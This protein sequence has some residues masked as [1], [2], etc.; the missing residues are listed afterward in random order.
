MRHGPARPGP[1]ALDPMRIV[2]RY[3]TAHAAGLDLC[4][5][6]D[7]PIELAPRARV[8]VATGLAV[9]I[10][11]G[12][13]GQVRPRSGLARDHG[14]TLLNSPGTIDADYTG[15][16]IVLLVNHGIG[17]V[18]GSR[19]AIAS[20]S[21]CDR[22][23]SPGGADRR[24]HTPGHGAWCGRFRI[25]RAMTDKPPAPADPELDLATVNE[26]PKPPTQ[27]T[28]GTS[29]RP[30]A[31]PKGVA[32]PSTPFDEV[33]TN[34]VEGRERDRQRAASPIHVFSMKTPGVVGRAASPVVAPQVQLRSLAGLRPPAGES[35]QARPARE[36]ERSAPGVR[37]TTQ[38][39]PRSSSCSRRRSRSPCGS[40]RGNRLW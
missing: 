3:M 4:A 37:A 22:A 31:P 26:R 38:P 10:P 1:E 33:K 23:G 16:L 34:V 27:P 19:T 36:S 12:Y 35:W 25:D 29:A 9:K 15:P 28:A 24:R 7:E 39:G 13:E 6:L 8:A 5:A 18:P 2:P 11:D 14:I 32:V 20:H 21:S 40:W 30:A 17:A